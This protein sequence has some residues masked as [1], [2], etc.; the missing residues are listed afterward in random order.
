[1]AF[2][3]SIPSATI[4]ELLTK[5]KD[6]ED[7]KGGLVGKNEVLIKTNTTPF[8][9]T[10]SYHPAT[11]KY[12]DDQLSSSSSP[13]VDL[14]GYITEVPVPGI[15]TIYTPYKLSDTSLLSRDGVWSKLFIPPCTQKRWRRQ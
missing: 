14:T 8:T 3:S 7:N 4:E 13:Y 15:W 2:E 11:K 1:M 5:A 6:V 9:P 12:V 10:S